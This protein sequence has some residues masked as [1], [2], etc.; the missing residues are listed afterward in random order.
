LAARVEVDKPGGSMP[1]GLPASTP[2]QGVACRLVRPFARKGVNDMKNQDDKS[3]LR[4]KRIKITVKRRTAK[5]T[6]KKPRR[7]SILKL[8]ELIVKIVQL[9]VLCK[10]Y[11]F[12]N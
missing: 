1:P 8:L 9:A 6:P 12:S 3:A 2:T 4:P 11:F 7:K 5:T 10:L